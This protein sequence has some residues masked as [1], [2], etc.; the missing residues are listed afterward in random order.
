MYLSLTH[1]IAMHSLHLPKPW[2]GW[3]LVVPEVPGQI[4]GIDAMR[5]VAI[6]TNGILVAIEDEHGIVCYGHLEWFVKDDA[7]QE[8]SLDTEQMIL[9]G[10]KARRVA[11]LI[12]E[13]A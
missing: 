8:T 3:R 13:Y 4:N 9:Q 7:E 1:F 6:A 2:D 5:G 10:R 11:E 12:E